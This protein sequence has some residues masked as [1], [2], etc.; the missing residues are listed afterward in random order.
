VKDI[1]RRYADLQVPRY[2]SYPTAAQ[3]TAD[4]RSEDHARWLQNV[5]RDEAISLYL[6]VPYCRDLCLYCG[7]NTKRALREDVLA[8]YRSAMEGEIAIVDAIL[9]EPLSV[10][11]VH[12]G[13]GTPS[14]LG[15]SGL[16]AVIEVLLRYYMPSSSIQGM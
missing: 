4:I 5:D 8:A 13:G 6:H 15:S 2:T 16:A 9:P 12:W 3:F 10:A 14:I 11:R 7:C 1:V